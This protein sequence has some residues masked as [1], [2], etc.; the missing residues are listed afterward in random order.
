MEDSGRQKKTKHSIVF[1]LIPTGKAA[2]Q[3]YEELNSHCQ[4]KYLMRSPSRQKCAF[5]LGGIDIFGKNGGFAIF[6]HSGM[7]RQPISSCP[8]KQE[9]TMRDLT[10]S[11]VGNE[12]DGFGWDSNTDRVGSHNRSNS[13][14]VAPFLGGELATTTE[15][16]PLEVAM[17]DQSPKAPLG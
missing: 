12:W 6:S 8:S 7:K 14:G 17:L 15:A 13:I 9:E 11:T 10:C 16:T 4:S 5:A 3:T 2:A 1:L